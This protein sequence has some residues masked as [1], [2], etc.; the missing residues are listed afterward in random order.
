MITITIND[1]VITSSQKL[2]TLKSSTRREAT[3]AKIIQALKTNYTK[4][5]VANSLPKSK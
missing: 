2:A 4:E 3:L 5:L 1:K